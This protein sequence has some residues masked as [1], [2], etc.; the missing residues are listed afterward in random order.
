MSSEW[1]L[2]EGFAGKDPVSRFLIVGGESSVGFPVSFGSCATSAAVS[3]GFVGIFDFGVR[4]NLA[5][6]SSTST[7][8][9]SVSASAFFSSLLFGAMVESALQTP[10]APKGD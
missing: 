9:A 5:H 6:S 10:T 4:F 7:V 3:G 8:E 1:E 2:V